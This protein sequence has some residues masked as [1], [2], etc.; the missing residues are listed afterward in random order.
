MDIYLGDFVSVLVSLLLESKLSFG[1]LEASMHFASRLVLAAE[2]AESVAVAALLVAARLVAARRVAAAH[3]EWANADSHAA[4]L[5]ARLLVAARLVAGL[6][7]S[8]AEKLW[9]WAGQTMS[10]EKKH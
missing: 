2:S 8:S 5:V 9:L 4:L 3:A 7:V 6:V 1:Q 10:C